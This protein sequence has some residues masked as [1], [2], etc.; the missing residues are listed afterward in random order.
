MKKIWQWIK[1]LFGKAEHM[2]HKYIMPAVT[3]VEALKTFVDS[4]V[5]DILTAIIPSTV[6]D[7]VKIT[8]RRVLPQVL[9]EMQIISDYEGNKD[10]PQ[11]VIELVLERVKQLSPQAQATFWHALAVMISDCMTDGHL[12]FS[13]VVH[14]VQYT[15][16]YL[17][18]PKNIK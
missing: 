3:V 5:A 10:D 2:V 12:S 9:L 4:P 7:A 14:L 6:D 11:K 18:K 16:D 13:E 15:Y 17:Y 1:G 8:L